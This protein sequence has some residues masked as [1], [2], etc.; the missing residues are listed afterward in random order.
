LTPDTSQAKDIAGVN[1]AIRQLAEEKDIVLA[2]HHAAVHPIWHTLTVDGLHPNHAGYQALAEIWYDAL[3]KHLAP[4]V[5]FNFT[6]ILHLLL[7]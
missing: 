4:E 3:L 5:S 6:P 1:Q 7:D 2:D